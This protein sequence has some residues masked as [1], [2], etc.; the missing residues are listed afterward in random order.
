MTF[1]MFPGRFNSARFSH[2]TPAR[3]TITLTNLGQGTPTKGT[4]TKGTV[5][6]TAF[7]SAF[8]LSPTTQQALRQQ[9]L[10]HA[11]QGRYE[12]AIALLNQLVEDNEPNA[13]DFNNR[14][15]LHFQNGQP[16]AA[17][18]DYDRA[19]QLNP[20]LAKVYNNRANCYAALGHLAEA[21]ADYE[22][23]IDLDPSN[24]N[25]WINQGITFRDLEMYGE[26]TENFDLA[27][28]FS[29]ILRG[30]DSNAEDNH[31]SSIQLGHI[32]AERGRTYHLAGDWNCAVAD[33]QRALASLPSIATAARTSSY[34]LHRQV[35]AWLEEL[36]HPLRL[37]DLDEEV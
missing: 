16:E 1:P 2:R 31:D 20:R 37:H 12:E 5:T 13:S 34:R 24:I 14:G 22:T 33:Y 21:I 10:S 18:A 35:A 29:Q 3:T 25:A 15:L 36:F 28:R 6:T 11:Q 32:Y 30:A 7:A 27:L 8:K 9:A 17:L 4:P 19:I 26:A 23:A